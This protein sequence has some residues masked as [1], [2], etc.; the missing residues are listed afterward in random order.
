MHNEYKSLMANGTWKLTTLPN[1][2]TRIGCKSAFR[3]KRDAL[4]HIVRYIARLVA[5]SF[6]QVRGVDFHKTFAPW[7]NS[8]P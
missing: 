6:A 5:K 2:H 8:P 3:A 7:P 1:N 4:G